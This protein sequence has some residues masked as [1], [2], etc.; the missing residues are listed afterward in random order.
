[1]TSRVFDNRNQNC[2]VSRARRALPD[3][4]IPVFGLDISLVL[5]ISSPEGM[6]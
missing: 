3:A 4:G 2:E 1:M 6:R 5:I